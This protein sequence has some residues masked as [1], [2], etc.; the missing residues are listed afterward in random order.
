MKNVNSVLRIKA[1]YKALLLL[2]NVNYFSD[3]L[4][5]ED[6]KALKN[7]NKDWVNIVGKCGEVE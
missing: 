6:Y 3:H 7:N 5:K 1:I 2:Y 4:F